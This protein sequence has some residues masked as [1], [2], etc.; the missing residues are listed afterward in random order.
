MRT[1]LL[2]LIGALLAG[3]AVPVGYAAAPLKITAYVNVT[4]GC[5]KPTEEL[6]GNLARKYAGR[7]AVETVDFGTPEGRKRWQGDGLH[8]M[9]ILLNGSAEADIV[10]KGAELH[11]AFQMPPGYAWLLDELETAV[12]QK[13]D[14]VAATDRQGPTISVATTAATT[15][16]RAGDTVIFEAASAAEAEQLRAALCAAAATR[17]LLQDDF[18]LDTA[19]GSAKVSLRGAALLDLGLV[20]GPVPAEAG[21]QAAARYLRLITPFPRQSRPFLGQPQPGMQ[22]RR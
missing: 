13:L 4:S 12:R 10:Y 15:S 7:V 16:V 11:V 20:E 9:T 19:T 1:W 3:V 5:Q 21:A 8:C 17:P 14:G 22:M 18:A 6:L 2:A